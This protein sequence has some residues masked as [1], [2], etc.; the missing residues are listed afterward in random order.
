MKSMLLAAR[1][2]TFQDAEKRRWLGS[3]F[4]AQPCRGVHTLQQEA[5]MKLHAPASI[6]CIELPL[7]TAREGG[8]QCFIL[9][10]HRQCEGVPPVFAR[11]A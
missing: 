11:A 7:E 4:V 9:H 1:Q 3:K 10:P 6:L 2:Y 8:S 5:D